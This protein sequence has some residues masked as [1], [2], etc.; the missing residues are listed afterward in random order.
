MPHLV[1]TSNGQPMSSGLPNKQL[2][3]QILDESARRHKH[4]CPRQ[5]LGARIGIRGLRELQLLAEN[6]TARFSNERKRLF[7]IVETDGCGLDG[8][9]VATDCAVGRRTLRVLDY[10]KVAATFVDTQNGRAVRVNPTAASRE[11]ALHYA[12]DAPSRWH[13]YLK[14][15]YL[16][17]DD[18]LL[19][20]V[21]VSLSPTVEE[22]ISKPGARCACAKCGEEIINER[23]VIVNECVLCRPCAGDTYYRAL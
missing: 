9:A 20:V 15:Y 1:S 17:P 7:T 14:A 21:D 23:E 5:V 22:I 19:H 2:L 8:I 4:L 13:A 18:D 16:I 12:P 6:G 10:G 3:E 11:L